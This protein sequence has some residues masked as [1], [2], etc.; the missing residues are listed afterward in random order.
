[1]CWF[2][3]VMFCVVLQGPP[4][5]GVYS[6]DLHPTLK[7]NEIETSVRTH[8]HKHAQK[9]QTKPSSWPNM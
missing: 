2:Y 4:F 7:L 9:Y 8:T 3:L 1:M 6:R 5:H